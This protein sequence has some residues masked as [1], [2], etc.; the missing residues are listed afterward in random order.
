[1][2]IR[3]RIED[4]VKSWPVYRQLAGT[5]RLGRRKAAK[6][7]VSGR[8]APRTDAADGVVKKR[9]GLDQAMDMA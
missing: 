7:R 2:G 6:S 9:L 5:D 4:Q 3:H 8:L 1:V